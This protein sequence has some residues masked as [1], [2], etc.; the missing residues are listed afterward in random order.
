MSKSVV[1]LD[2]IHAL[3]RIGDIARE[4]TDLADNATPNGDICPGADDAINAIEDQLL[5]VKQALHSWI[6]R[7]G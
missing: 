7:N 3:M 6:V 5:R 4:V 2:A 1:E